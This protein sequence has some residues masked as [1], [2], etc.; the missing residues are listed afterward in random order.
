MAAGMM[1]FVVYRLR[2]RQ[3]VHRTLELETK[4]AERTKV[5]VEQSTE[6]EQAN[7]RLNQSNADLLST[8]NQLRLGVVITD[9]NACVNFISETAEALLGRNNQDVVGR[10]WSEALPLKP[11]DLDQL[12]SMVGLPREKRIKTPVHVQGSGSRN[13]WMEI[14]ALDDPRDPS[15]K[16]FCLYD[17]SEIYGLRRNAKSPES[18]NQNRARSM[19][20]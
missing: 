3:L 5:I 15:R 6:L 17:V 4:V 20:A 16:I 19:F 18:E 8:L 14:E 13:Y 11:H 7:V 9:H 12:K 10:D 1:A 2:V